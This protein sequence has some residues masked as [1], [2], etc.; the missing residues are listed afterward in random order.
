VTTDP[1]FI[2]GVE[3]SASDD[4]IRQAYR[5]LAREL[6]PDL[7][8]GRDSEEAFKALGLAHAVLSDAGRRR[9]YDQFG[10]ASLE[11]GFEP[12]RGA[13]GPSAG[14]A[15]PSAGSAEAARSGGSGDLVV[16]LEIDLLAAITG[17]PQRVEAPTGATLTVE[18]PPDAQSGQQIRLPGRGRPGR[19]GARPGDLYCEIVVRPHPFLQRQGRDLVLELPVTIDE[20][21]RGAQIEIPTLD[22]WA[23]IRIPKGSRGGE[24]LRLKGQGIGSGQGRGDLLVHLCVRLPERLQSAGRIL[25]RLDGLYSGSVRQGLKL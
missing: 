16:P 17:G 11:P 6:H 8:P 15:Q 12:G 1:Y 22:G 19:Q 10:A 13:P 5:R 25:E 24:R 2:L 4:E 21:H 20:A 23:R 3:R 18:V 14:P 7:H 9:L